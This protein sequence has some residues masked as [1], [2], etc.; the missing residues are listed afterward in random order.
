M[1][2][3]KSHCRTAR[4]KNIIFAILIIFLLNIILSSSSTAIGPSDKVGN[5]LFVNKCGQ[6]HS[7]VSGIARP[8]APTRYAASQWARF[9]KKN[10]HLRRKDLS[11]YVSKTDLDIIT[12]YLMNHAADSDLPEAS[13]LFLD[14]AQ[15]IFNP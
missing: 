8:F 10:R 2:F 15:E 6:C 13:G 1:I 9:F 7:G 14:S 4:L 11:S 5:K 3:K 12:I